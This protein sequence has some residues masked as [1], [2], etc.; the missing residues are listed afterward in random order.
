[1][2]VFDAMNQSNCCTSDYSSLI[3]DS[4]R[5][6]HQLQLDVTE[7]LKSLD[8][9]LRVLEKAKNGSSNN[10]LPDSAGA[11]VVVLAAWKPRHMID[12][13]ALGRSM[14]QLDEICSAI[15]S[16]N[17]FIQQELRDLLGSILEMKK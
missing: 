2:Q 7:R 11:N 5:L 17:S 15:D 4:L 6:V 8:R 13:R 16:T 10:F 1:M 12:E 14:K 3:A 9:F